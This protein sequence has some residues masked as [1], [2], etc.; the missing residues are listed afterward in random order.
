MIRERI[1]LD[2]TYLLPFFQLPLAV[3][4]FDRHQF[5][6]LLTP[7]LSIHVAAVSLYEL[8]A[9]LIRLKRNAQIPEQIFSA[10]WRNWTILTEDPKFIIEAYCEPVDQHVNRISHEFPSLGAFDTVILAMAMNVGVLLTEDAAI[11][12]VKTKPFFRDLHILSWR[13]ARESL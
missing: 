7:Y 5:K 11:H 8:K 2:T 4:H 9:K 1:L 13:D 12:T 6:Q 3:D 10:F